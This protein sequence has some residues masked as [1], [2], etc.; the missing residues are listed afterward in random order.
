MIIFA[1]HITPRL[2]YIAKTLFGN[3]TIVTLDV[4]RFTNSSLQKINYSSTKFDA[5]SLWIRPYGLLEQTGITQQNINCF[6]WQHLP[7]FFKTNGDVPFDILSAAFYLLTR[8]EEYFSDYKT[9]AYGNYHHDNSVAY[10]NNFLHLPLI[11]LWLKELGN[12]SKLNIQHTKFSIVPT[13]DVDIAF[14]YKH[15]SLLRNIGG[16]VKDILQQRG[17]FFE[18]IN[19]LINR[20]KDVYD[21]FDWLHHLHQQYSLNPI[22]F[23]LVAQHRSRFDKN[24]ARNSKGM[25]ELVKAIASKQ[26]MGIHPSFISNADESVLQNEIA[27]LANTTHKKITKNRQHYLQ[28]KFPETYERLIK[29][30]ISEDYTMGYGTHNGF[31]ASYCK[32]F[33]WYNLKDEKCTNLLLHPFCY[34]DSNSIFEQQLTP[35]KAQAE[36]HYYH[37]IVKQV[38]GNFIFIMH[39]H[40]LATQPQWQQWQVCYENFLATI[41]SDSG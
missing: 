41:F 16:F 17:T 1:Q 37:N 15:H 31:R 6:E 2:Q 40:F 8:Y 19:V 34:M 24:A 4:H 38:D 23:F 36:M 33:F 28:L 25:L 35:Q 7:V 32:S 20:K 29:S 13:Y 27:F 14:A 22:Y 30:D 10:K 39:N 26:A 5:D 21:V 9:D 12:Y 3:N 11:N 18:R